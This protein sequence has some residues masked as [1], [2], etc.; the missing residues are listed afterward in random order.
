VDG[1]EYPPRRQVMGIDRVSL[2]RK[3]KPFNVTLKDKDEYG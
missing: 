1:T 2:W 3:L